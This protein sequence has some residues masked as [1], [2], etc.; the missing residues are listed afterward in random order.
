LGK[1]AIG[2]GIGIVTW[3]CPLSAATKGEFEQIDRLISAG[4]HERALGEVQ[5]LREALPSS[6]RLT[7]W[8][9]DYRGEVLRVAQGRQCLYYLLHLINSHED[10]PGRNGMLDSEVERSGRPSA[11]VCIALE[12][13]KIRWSRLVDGP[14]YLAVDPQSDALYLYYLDV[15]RQQV[16]ALASDSGKVLQQHD[17]QWDARRVQGLLIGQSLAVTQPHSGRRIPNDR[18]FVYDVRAKAIKE[19]EAGDY[20]FLAPDES[21]RLR[22][23]DGGWD[24]VSVPDGQKQWS[25]QAVFQSGSVPLWHGGHPTFVVGTEWQRG[26]ITSIDAG[27]GEPRWS[28]PLG[29]GAYTANQHQLRGGGYQDVWTP[30]EAMDE[31]LLAL[32]GSG[33]LYLLDPKDG[34][35]VATPRLDRNYLAMPFQYGKQLIVSSFTWVRSYSIA[36]LIRPDASAD[37]SLQIRQSRCLL[38]LGRKEE[39]MELIDRLVERAPQSGAAWA[40]RAV[41][42]NALNHAEEEAFSRCRELSLT[43]RVSDDDLRERWGLLRL[44]NLESK[45]AWTL[46]EVEGHVCAG[47]LV[48]DLW[49][50]RTNSLDI[51]RAARLDREITKLAV[52]TELQ[53]MLDN[54][55]R[56]GQPIPETPAKADDRI[57][58]EWYR[59]GGEQRISQPVSY[60]DRQFRS[61]KGGGVRILSGTEMSDLPSK[62]E[63]VG[64]WLIHLSPSGPLGFG[65]GVFEL[66]DDLRPVRWLIRPTVGGDLPEWVQVLFIRSSIRTIGLVVGSSYGAAV[67]VYSRHGKLLAEAPL[68]RYASS[69]VRPTAFVL[70]GGGY[71]FCDRQ[72]VWVGPDNNRPVWRFGPSFARTSTERWAERWRYFGDPLQTN[73]CLYVTGLDGQLYVFDSA[74]VTGAADP[75]PSCPSVMPGDDTESAGSR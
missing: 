39:A 71:L 48:G 28:T 73:G 33:R 4:E 16:L 24:C 63:D 62:L 67:Q 61:I 32:G 60:R 18:L 41:V 6:E 34:R 46:K 20:W 75:P 13:G 29:W 35:P 3:A 36:N 54:S 70:M 55:L 22:P 72:L 64:D 5:R 19:V 38:A 21:R 42:C 15:H 59:S 49:R 40:E 69:F 56:P 57:P 31:Y 25:L 47:T 1:V 8:E 2:L 52:K 68:G 12:T 53:A 11:V 9:L 45:P 7:A 26:A 65:K 66:D 74:H 10:A 43:G 27:T 37:V 44:H 23:F 51:D 14:V 30:I 17:L 50:V 58:R